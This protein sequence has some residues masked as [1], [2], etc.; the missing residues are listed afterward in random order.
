MQPGAAAFPGRVVLA[1]RV[2]AVRGV[3]AFHFNL[4]EFDEN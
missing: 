2:P 4:T 3:P 1:G